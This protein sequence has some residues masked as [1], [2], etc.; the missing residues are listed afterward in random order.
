M[1]PQEIAPHYSHPVRQS[2]EGILDV[3]CLPGFVTGLRAESAKD[4]EVRTLTTKQ[5]RRVNSGIAEV[6]RFLKD[7]RLA[8]MLFPRPGK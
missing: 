5:S 3:A 2:I 7:L 8:A 4:E 1:C 6:E